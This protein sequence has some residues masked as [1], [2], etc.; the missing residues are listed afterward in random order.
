MMSSMSKMRIRDL[1]RVLRVL[2][3]ITHLIG[4]PQ[5]LSSWITFYVIGC[6][7]VTDWSG[8]ASM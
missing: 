4:S 3:D 2:L 5:H 6:G 1:M 8:L 7:M